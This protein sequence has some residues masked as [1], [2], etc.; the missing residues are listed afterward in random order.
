MKKTIAIL[1]ILLACLLMFSACADGETEQGYE[2]YN[3]YDG[4]TMVEIQSSY[5]FSIFVHKE[6]KVMYVY[7][8]KKGDADSGGITALIDENGKPLLYEGTLD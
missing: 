6:T 3:V 1:I 5:K 4:V 8:G 2:Y 7:S